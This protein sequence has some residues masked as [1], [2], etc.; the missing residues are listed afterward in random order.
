MQQICPSYY[1]SCSFVSYFFIVIVILLEHFRV[2][3]GSL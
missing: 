3:I 2:V 1:C